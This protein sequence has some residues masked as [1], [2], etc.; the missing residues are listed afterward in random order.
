MSLALR[1]SFA[2]PTSTPS[3]FAGHMARTLRDL[4]RQLQDIDL[5]IEARDA[6]LPLT[7][8][9]GAFDTMLERAWGGRPGAATAPAAAAMAGGMEGMGAGLSESGT[10]GEAG[11]SDWW[12]KWVDRKGKGKEKIV[13]YTKRDLAESKYEEPLIRA[14]REHAGQRV[15]FA[16]TRVDKD[17]RQIIRLA[18]DMARRHRETMPEGMKVLVVGMPNV[19][20]S[21]LLNALRRVGVQK[22]KAF[23]TGA[24][25][26]LTRKFTGTVKIHESPNI[27]VSDTPGVMVPYLGKG[28]KGA[29]KGLKLALTAGIKEDLFEE[30]V[31]ADYLLWRMN[32][33]L[34]AERYLLPDRPS[35]DTSHTS[36]TSLLPLPP[37]FEPTDDLYVLLEALADRLGTLRKGGE[38]DLD[39]ARGY[40]IRAFREGKLGQWTLDD[41]ETVDSG[42]LATSM[43]EVDDER[44]GDVEVLR[45]LR[46]GLGLGVGVGVGGVTASVVA[47]LPWA[48]A[49]RASTTSTTDA[50]GTT[51]TSEA[52]TASEH[53]SGT[54]T[55][56]ATNPVPSEMSELDRSNPLD[57]DQRV[58]LAVK[59]F[60]ATSSA[61]A[62][63]ALEPADVSITQQRKAQT[64]KAA[65]ERTAKLRA[66]GVDVDG[67]THDWRRAARPPRSGRK[68]RGGRRRAR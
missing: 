1:S 49:E 21:S 27:Y 10:T 37:S 32:Q 25:P 4:P 17:I 9:N 14:F 58:S 33:R 53:E 45:D 63:N 48:S 23:R 59:S 35:A 62:S 5:V 15:L 7:S 42:F 11:R 31:V 38:R 67:K 28:E 54:A 8:V 22:G 16:D 29:E 66:K 20:K 57:L 3:W 51:N 44:G 68:G 6:R 61:S 24:S 64:R 30:E 40:L 55:A 19:G 13:V 52:S 12:G 47:D 26:G 43:V 56:T 60:L 36:Y 41:L 34:V 46:D 39:A 18:V 65:E 2:F 50:T